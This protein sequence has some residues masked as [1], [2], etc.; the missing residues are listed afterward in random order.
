[1]WA[2]CGVGR[3]DVY[4]GRASPGH[5]F[6]LV[7]NTRFHT[8]LAS[9]VTYT[10]VRTNIGI[11][12][13]AWMRPPGGI[14]ERQPASPASGGAKPGHAQSHVV[15]ALWGSGD[16]AADCAGGAGA[17]WATLH[18]G[19]ISLTWTAIPDEISRPSGEGYPSLRARADIAKQPGSIGFD[20]P[21]TGLKSARTTNGA[22]FTDV[23]AL[24]HTRSDEELESGRPSVT[25]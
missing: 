18:S 22:R 4:R 3:R 9:T 15:G 12:R 20:R 23:I 6:G 21:R 19:R 7:S 1:M 14:C 24:E 16:D 11:D 5:T 8:V 13:C 17:L 25:G 10:N 2:P